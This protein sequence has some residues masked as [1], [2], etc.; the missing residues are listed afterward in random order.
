MSYRSG[1]VVLLWL[2]TINTGLAQNSSIPQLSS[3]PG[4]AFTVY[5]NFGGFNYDG[6]WFG[7]TPGVT[8][9]YDTNDNSS[10]FTPTEITNMRNIWS[11]TAEKFSIFNVNITTLD[12]AVAAGQSSSDAQRLTYYDVTP[13]MMH[14]VIGGDGAWLNS[15]GAVGVSG[16]DVIDSAQTGG[17]HTNWTFASNYGTSNNQISLRGVAETIAHENGHAFGL[18]HQSRWNGNTL[19]EEYH[20]G[21]ANR[22]PIMGNSDYSARGLWRRGTSGAG[23]DQIQNDL[24]R[25]LINSGITGNG[26]AGYMDS[27]IGHTRQ[28]ATTLPM[29]GTTIDS[30]TAKGIITPNSASDPNPLGEANYTTDFFKFT[31][32]AG[33]ANINVTLRSG[34]STITP[35]TADPGAM[36][37]ATLRLLDANGNVIATA[38]LDT[39]EEN[40]TRN[41]LAE[42]I[43]F[44]QISSAGAHA[45]Y[46]DVGS[47]FLTGSIVPVP[48]PG[49]ILLA[50]IAVLGVGFGMLR[51]PFGQQVALSS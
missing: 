12:P 8:P 17:M 25:I 31:V 1:V 16:F 21:D 34:L 22:A 2:L 13:R 43:Y 28:T 23:P 27:G 9:A 38:N 18:D 5:L 10:V 26:V 14:T 41:N 3:R 51:L 30:S 44:L 49:T 4:A 15:P 24:A 32:G 6:A 39:F 46:F 50:S 19:S 47:Y 42:G 37:D 29:N 40:I 45:E 7:D 35:G 33:G 36:L 48:E 11:R 20:S